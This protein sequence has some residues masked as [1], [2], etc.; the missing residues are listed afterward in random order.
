[1]CDNPVG[2]LA[3]LQWVWP[4]AESI[5][6]LDRYSGCAINPGLKSKGIVGAGTLQLIPVGLLRL[7]VAG[8]CLVP[9]GV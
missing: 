9:Q 7:R 1:M 8:E 2:L 6:A 4:F 3:S 5:R